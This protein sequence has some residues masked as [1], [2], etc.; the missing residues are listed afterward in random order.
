MTTREDLRV[1]GD[2]TDYSPEEIE[3]LIARHR[4]T[5]PT[6]DD[7]KVY[8]AVL[9]LMRADHKYRSIEQAKV[10]IGLPGGKA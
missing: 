4:M 2:L 6:D 1:C 5:W 7:A 3:A 10:S 8:A 9:A